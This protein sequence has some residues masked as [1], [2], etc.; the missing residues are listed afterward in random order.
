MSDFFYNSCPPPPLN[1]GLWQSEGARGG[2]V[3]SAATGDRQGH[4]PHGGVEGQVHRARRSRRPLQGGD[5]R[6]DQRR[7]PDCGEGEGC[8]SACRGDNCVFPVEC[9]PVCQPVS[10]DCS[11]PNTQRQ[12]LGCSLSQRLR[13]W[14]SGTTKKVFLHS[15]I[16]KAHCLK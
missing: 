14:I 12:S 3:T 10:L 15:S 7:N 8:S 2:D 13:R 9:A 6:R 5:G 4:S 1:S 11:A 16:P